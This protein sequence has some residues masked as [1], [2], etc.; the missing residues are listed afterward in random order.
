[1]NLY[2]WENKQ[3]Q[4]N[5]NKIPL[6]LA[7]KKKTQKKKRHDMKHNRYGY[8]DRYETMIPIGE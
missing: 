8:P 6:P 3:K 2:V 1:M 7:K 4:K 5:K